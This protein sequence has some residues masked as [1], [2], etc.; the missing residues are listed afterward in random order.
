MFKYIAKIQEEFMK[1]ARSWEDLPHE[2]QVGY[3]K[4]HPGTR[5]KITAPPTPKSP[6]S[7]LKIHEPSRG[8]AHPILDLLRSTTNAST[9]K[10][11]ERKYLTMREGTHNKFH[12]FVVFPTK[13]GQYAA[14]NA[15]GRI[16]YE[17]KA[18]V[19]AKSPSEDGA[20]SA[21]NDK[22]QK[23]LKKGYQQSKMSS[24]EDLTPVGTPINYSST[25]ETDSEQLLK[26]VLKENKKLRKMLEARRVSI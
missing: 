12:Y 4:R 19:F 7:G 22:L 24:E 13:D 18:I 2:Y 26:D 20:I 17:P 21:M 15:Y 6:T 8:H 16:G 9:D 11:I 23:K 5:R 25:G 10:P 3:L 14:A 1:F